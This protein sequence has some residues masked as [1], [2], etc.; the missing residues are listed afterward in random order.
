MHLFDAPTLLHE[1]QGQP[2]EQLGVSRTLSHLT[3][4]VQTADDATAEVPV[5]Y[6]IH[7]DSRGQ[8]MLLTCKPLR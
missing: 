8:R 2:V 7:H 3:E 1:C 5:P 4:V 6:A